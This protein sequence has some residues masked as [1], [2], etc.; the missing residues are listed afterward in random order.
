[1]NGDVVGVRVNVLV[2]DDKGASIAEE[3]AA[4]SGVLAQALTVF[5]MP[6]GVLV[7]PTV[8]MTCLI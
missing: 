6:G 5:T 1:M 7:L 8:V 3:Q 4:C 2:E